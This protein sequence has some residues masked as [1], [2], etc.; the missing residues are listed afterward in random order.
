MID[1]IIELMQ[2]SSIPL[3]GWV[4]INILL[5]GPVLTLLFRFG[6]IILKAV[7]SFFLPYWVD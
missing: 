5:W 6:G 4:V 2:N 3:W 7:L 1:W